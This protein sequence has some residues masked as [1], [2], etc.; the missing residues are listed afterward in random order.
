[1]KIVGIVC[2]SI[3]IC[4]TLADSFH[5]SADALFLIPTLCQPV[6]TNRT[7]IKP[8]W[9]GRV[10]NCAELQQSSARTDYWEQETHWQLE[11]HLTPFRWQPLHLRDN[12]LVRATSN[13]LQHCPSPRDPLRSTGY[14][15]DVSPL[16][17]LIKRF[18]CLGPQ[19]GWPELAWPG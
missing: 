8:S 16:H 4:N 11:A 5:L 10:C 14:S 7:E 19:G 17:N 6:T 18:L 2:S 1:M 15:C 9:P 13:T 12:R 3:C